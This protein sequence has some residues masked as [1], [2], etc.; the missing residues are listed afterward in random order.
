MMKALLFLAQRFV[1]NTREKTVRIM[2]A[3]AFFS[4]MTGACALALVAA[5]MNGFEHSTRRIIQG[6]HPDI[7]ITA[8]PDTINPEKLYEQLRKQHGPEITG[9]SPYINQHALLKL[10][11]SDS[12]AEL[13][14]ITGIDP[15]A[16]PMVTSLQQRITE[17][18]GGTFK[19]LLAT[20]DQTVIGETLAHVL[21]VKPG[22]KIE[23]VY[24][25][26]GLRPAQKDQTPEADSEIDSNGE[27]DFEQ[28]VVTIAGLFK[29]GIDAI[30]AHVIYANIADVKKIFASDTLSHIG[31]KVADPSHEKSLIGEIKNA[32]QCD[33]I[34]W[35]DLYPALLSALTL[36]KYASILI[37]ALIIL[38][39]SANIFA[40]LFMFIAYKKKEIAL[41]RTL[42]LTMREITA[43]F[44]FIGVGLSMFA[45]VLGVALASVAAYVLKHY[46][47]ITLPDVYY[48]NSLPAEMTVFIILGVLALVF[49][50][51]LGASLLPARFVGKLEVAEI[52]KESV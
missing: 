15:H 51:S 9:I 24:T 20:A 39:A 16:E 28:H 30:D 46:P 6:I 19:Q 45:S 12:I 5:V 27:L 43:L 34:S 41:L 31:I 44:V 40:L 13:A 33:V 47:I 22:D 14:V 25:K 26:K 49:F 18:A 37:L 36:E 2:I 7:I 29:T 21:G 42:G 4:I 32:T 8:C 10:P 50:M 1:R 23:L 11:E 35:Q 38:I 52:L 48:V 3:V 17:P